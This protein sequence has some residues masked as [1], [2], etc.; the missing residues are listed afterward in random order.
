MYPNTNPIRLVVPSAGVS[1]RGYNW[2][3]N[4]ED[5]EGF[6]AYAR[7]I[8]ES[9]FPQYGM[10]YDEAGYTSRVYG[11]QDFVKIMNIAIVLAAFSS[12]LLFFCLG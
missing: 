12:T 8:L 6:M 1:V 7:D 11:A 10:D 4:P 9:Y 5:E 2:M 3:A